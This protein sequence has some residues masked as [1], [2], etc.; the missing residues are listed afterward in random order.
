MRHRISEWVRYGLAAG[1]FITF[2]GSFALNYRQVEEEQEAYGQLLRTNSWIAVQLEVEYLFLRN[3]LDRFALGDPGTT[4]DEVAHR[5][6][7]LWSRF[8]VALIGPEAKLLRE[9]AGAEDLLQDLFARLQALEPVILAAGPKD[10][11]A[12]NEARRRLESFEAPLHELTMAAMKGHGTQQLRAVL[13][14]SH[15]RSALH[16]AGMFGACG[17]LMLILLAELSR[18]RRIARAEHV[19]R[20]DAD[21]ANRAKSEFLANMSHELRTPLNAIIGFSDALRIGIAGPLTAKQAEYLVDVRQAGEHLL[22]IISDVLDLS[23]VEAGRLNL[24]EQEVDLRELASSCL[25]L[26]REKAGLKGL[27]ISVDIAPDLPSVLADPVRIKQVLLNLLGNAVKFTPREGSVAIRGEQAP[28]EGVLISIRDTGPGMTPE[29]VTLALEPFCQ[30]QRGTN[31]PH[32]GTGLG[33]PLAKVLIQAH[34]GSLSI[35]SH[36]GRGTLIRLW[37]PPDRIARPGSRQ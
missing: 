4:R 29:E 17:L 27:R 25:S 21:L 23:K 28:D 26:V 19:A 33:L 12:Y 6:D 36:V 10:L 31:R 35:D 11:Q 13:H 2:T 1:L 34:G 16:L 30:I 22:A 37:L 8:P 18:N 3:A 32:E 24:D 5:L 20:V 9:E 14:D 7:L 15:D